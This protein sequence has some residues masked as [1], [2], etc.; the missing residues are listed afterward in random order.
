VIC[1][2]AGDLPVVSF[3]ARK[4]GMMRAFG[5][6]AML[7]AI[8]A[9]GYACGQRNEHPTGA[10]SDAQLYLIRGEVI[11]VPQV[12]KPGTE[13]IVKHEPV[14]N[15]RNA[16]GQIVGMSTMGMPFSP[17]KGVLLDGIKRG[18]KIEM[19]W[20]MQ[21]KPEAKEYVDSVRKLPMETQLRFGDAHP[22]T[23]S[24][25]TMPPGAR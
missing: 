8:I 5:I 7:G 23:T 14:D 19:R 15:F 6:I 16:S 4:K 17:G 3:D 12:G 2:A 9:T 21:W 10:A 24:P 1:G 25:G 11:S 20:V 13:F 18:D 22:T